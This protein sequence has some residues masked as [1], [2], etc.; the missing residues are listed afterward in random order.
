MPAICGSSTLPKVSTRPTMSAATSAPRTEPMPPMTTTTK[1]MI[2]TELPMPGYTLEMGEAIMPAMAARAT[3]SAN[4][5][6]WI[7]RMLM[8][9]ASVISRLK[10]PARIFM[11]RRV[12]EIRRYRPSASATHTAEITSR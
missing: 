12:F 8:P 7:R 5:T 4:T 1:H 9:R 2:S 6:P 10:A 11:P 3:P